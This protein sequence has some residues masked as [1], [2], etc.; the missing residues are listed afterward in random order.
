MAMQIV[1]LV[2]EQIV[3]PAFQN[4]LYDVVCFIADL[5]HKKMSNPT[6]TLLSVPG[7]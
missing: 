4:H 2:N 7:K 6:L 5:S 1:N 3:L